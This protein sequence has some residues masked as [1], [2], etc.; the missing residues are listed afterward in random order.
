MRI[1]KQC[2]IRNIVLAEPSPAMAAPAA[3]QK[4]WNVRAEEMGDQ[5]RS[6]ENGDPET[7][8]VITCL[9]NVL[10]HVRGFENRVRAMRAMKQ[11]LSPGGKCFLD[12]NHRYNMR[13]Y[14][15]LPTLKR[16]IEDSIS[17]KQK[18][19]DVIATWKIRDGSISTYGHVF[20]DREVR[21]LARIAGLE[22]EER[23]A[24]DYESGKTRRFAFAGSLLY[25]LR[26]TSTMDSARPPQTS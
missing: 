18:N 21:E 19:A 9:W 24:V 5:L 2:G 26:R 20:T 15:M 4:I 22:I 17:Y 25:V 8:D 1:A 12:V 11:L 10:G 6:N 16:F 3:G 14:G 7:F 23:I 13:A